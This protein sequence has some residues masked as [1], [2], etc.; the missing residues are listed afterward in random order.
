MVDQAKK[1]GGG[2]GSK[3]S[4][5]PGAASRKMKRARSWYR[6]QTRKDKNVFKSS[7]GKFRSVNELEAHH[8]KV[9]G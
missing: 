5:L 8:K 2:K 3:S 6:C 7:H 9:S 1:T 4:K